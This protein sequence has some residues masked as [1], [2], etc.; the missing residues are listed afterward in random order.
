MEWLRLHPYVAGLG[1][2]GVLIVGGVFVVVEK[3]PGAPAPSQTL[4]WGG[5]G[6][7]LNPSYTPGTSG[8]QENTVGI[9]Q[10]VQSDA[11]YSYILPTPQ[12]ATTDGTD[13]TGVGFDFNAFI[14]MLSAEK[15]PPAAGQSVGGN[16]VTDA[17]AFI[18]GGLIST[19]TQTAKRTKLQD[20]LYSYGNDVGSLIQSFEQEHG[21]ESQILMD[22]AQDRSDTDKAAAVQALAAALSALG[23]SLLTMDN[24]PSQVSAAHQAL[25]QSYKDI[26]AKLT[27]VP[28]AQSNA[29][30]I[31]AVESYDAS[32]NIFTQNYVALANLFPAYGVVFA[33]G[34]PGSVFT[35]SPS[36]L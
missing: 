3:S 33:S 4:A 16:V 1:A 19:S 27:L 23:D 31:A 8:P 9:M 13:A 25:G 24:L 18:P 14:S 30:F 22:Q 26:A 5:A 32:A 34:D 15:N 28:Q 36:G 21:N 29:D 20:S 17:Y 35:F 6:A 10:A 2:A 12:P 11:P 7:A